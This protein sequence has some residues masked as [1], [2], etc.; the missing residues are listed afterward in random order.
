MNILLPDD[1]QCVGHT[2]GEYACIKDRPFGIP[3]GCKG[4]SLVEHI[5]IQKQH[6]GQAEDP[7]CEELHAGETDSVGS[8]FVEMID[9]D[10]VEGEDQRASEKQKV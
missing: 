3:D 10:D 4:Y 9:C 6:S 7:G 5:G 1:L 2:A 8:F